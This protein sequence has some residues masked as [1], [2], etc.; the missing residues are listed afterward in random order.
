MPMKIFPILL[1]C[2]VSM[3]AQAADDITARKNFGNELAACSAYYGAR[4]NAPGVS[5]EEYQALGTKSQVALRAAA[6]VTNQQYAMTRQAEAQ[7]KPEAI[8]GALC[9]QVMANPKDR[10]AYWKGH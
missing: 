4:A 8:N 6:R 9:D 3:A 7:G 5:K 1:L 2:G 10:F